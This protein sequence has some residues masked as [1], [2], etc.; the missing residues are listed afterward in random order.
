MGKNIL[1]NTC[2]GDFLEYKNRVW[3]VWLE[4]CQ[5][6]VKRTKRTDV[7]NYL[8]N[9]GGHIICLQETTLDQQ[10]LRYTENLLERG[11]S[12]QQQQDKCKGSGDSIEA[13]LWV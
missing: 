6:T 13:R 4:C 7:L 9:L 10:R 8:E 3:K 11:S 5:Q 1:V 12:N 2:K